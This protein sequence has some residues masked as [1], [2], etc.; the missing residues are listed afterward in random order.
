MKLSKLP[1]TQW[2]LAILFTMS[3]VCSFAQQ[4][5]TWKGGTPG[6]ENE[7][8]CP[9]NWSSTSLPDEFSDVIIP[10]V[11]SSTFAPPCINEGQIEI[12]SLRL[13]SNA[14]VTIA[15]NAS[16]TVISYIE[17]LDLKKVKGEGQLILKED[18][19][20]MSRLMTLR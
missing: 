4:R 16:L 15:D 14:S 20:S 19:P 6:M 12:N 1:V 13:L 10:D 18:L 5:I 7:W 8:Y 3:T 9:Q 11:S 2:I 17:G